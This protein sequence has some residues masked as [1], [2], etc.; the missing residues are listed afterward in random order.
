MLKKIILEYQIFDC[1]VIQTC[2]ITKTDYDIQFS[3]DIEPSV[4]QE[5]TNFGKKVYKSLSG[6][7]IILSTSFASRNPDLLVIQ[8]RKTLLSCFWHENT[9]QLKAIKLLNENDQEMGHCFSNIGF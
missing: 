5:I 6:L 7:F 3:D 4:R 8:I 1:R 2:D 9:R